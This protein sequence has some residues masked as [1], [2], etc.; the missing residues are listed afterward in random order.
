[1][2]KFDQ[3]LTKWNRQDY[4]PTDRLCGA[5]E[6]NSLAFFLHL[7]HLNISNNLLEFLLFAFDF[8]INFFALQNV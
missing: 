1:M 4:R 8:V 5:S 6:R 7:I 2:N 3:N